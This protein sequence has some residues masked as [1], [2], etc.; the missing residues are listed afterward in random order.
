MRS[1]GALPR[2]LLPLRLA[3]RCQPHSTAAPRPLRVWVKC[4]G[5]G[6]DTLRGASATFESVADLRAAV[7]AAQFPPSTRPSQLQLRLVRPAPAGRPTAAEEAAA[8]PLDP[9][10]CWDDVLAGA[11]GAAGGSVWLLAA[12]E[13]PGLDAP[14][15]FAPQDV[16]GARMMVAATPGPFFLTP[17]EH[18][19]LVEFLREGPRDY[20]RMLMLT[21]TI[22]SGKSRLVHDIIPRMLAAEHA[23]AGGRRRHPYLFRHTFPP[24]LAPPE[25]AGSLVDALH[26]YADSVGLPLARRSTP[27]LPWQQG[28]PRV[29]MPGAGSCGS[30]WMSWG[31]PLLLRPRQAVPAYLQSSSSTCVVGRP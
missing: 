8:A 23:A 10:Q 19:T 1:L 31:H 26:D 17:A 16:G 14:L 22:K 13:P 29:S 2:C 3:H 15:A 11:L 28:W 9:T 4:E 25:A 5:A 20:P 7:A 30:S 12:A 6:W 21:G 24:T 18:A 27:S